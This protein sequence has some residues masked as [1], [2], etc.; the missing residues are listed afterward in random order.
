MP[1]SCDRAAGIA[2][3]FLAD[4]LLGD[5]RRGHPVAG[6]GTGA[7]RLEKLTYA[8]HR[9]AGVLH[10][11]LLLGGLGLLGFA[12]GGRASAAGRGNQAWVT[13]VATYIALGGTS[14]N[15]VGGQMATLLQTADLDGARQLLPSLCGRDPAALDASG[16]TRATVESL[17]ENTS[18]AQ[19]APLF[20]AAIG[21]VPGVLVYRGAN[22]LDAMIGNRSPRYARFGWAAARFDDVL[23]Y[24]P[25]RL[26]GVLAA[27]CAPVVGGSPRAALRA[28]H[29][30]AA[31]HPSPNAGVAEAS[32]AGAL[33]VRLGGPTQYAHQLEIRPTL[34]DGRIPEVAD[35]AR[36][37]RLSRA[38]QAGAALVAI[39]LSGAFRSGRRS[40]PR[41]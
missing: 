32:F 2:V 3:G 21:G 27:V 41:R 8:D 30:D 4:L 40:S 22:T 29:R 1:R 16:L 19:V 35:V 24:L 25:A 7:A 36:A 17:A 18:D 15:R 12:V 39:A 34:G 31:R 33:G 10:T 5:P 38:V 28:W 14:L 26:T 11:G 37:V 20:W 9:G 6:F 23:N 13:A